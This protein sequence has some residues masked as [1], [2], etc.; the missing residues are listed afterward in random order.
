MSSGLAGKLFGLSSSSLIDVTDLALDF[1]LYFLI[2]LNIPLHVLGLPLNLTLCVFNLSF[3]SLDVFYFSYASVNMFFHPFTL[4]LK[5]CAHFFL[6]F[7]HSILR[8]LCPF[9]HVQNA[10]LALFSL[11]QLP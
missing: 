8:V 2:P 1:A 3:H 4:T 10:S 9:S 7:L 6:P 5:V 11:V